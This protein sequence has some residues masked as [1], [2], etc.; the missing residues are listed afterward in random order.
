MITHKEIEGSWIEIPDHVLVYYENNPI[1]AMFQAVYHDF[2]NYFYDPHYIKNRAVV[3]PY[4]ETA[5]DFNEYTLGLLPGPIR[6][7]LSSEKIADSPMTP[8]SLKESYPTEFLNKLTFSGL[9]NRRLNLKIGC[10]IMLLRNISQFTRLCNG[11]RLLVCQMAPNVIEA[12]IISG[13]HIG[14]RVFIPRII[15]IA[16]NKKLP[17]I[18][19]RK[20]FS[21]RVCYAMTINKSQGQSLDHVG[22]FLP[23]PVFS[24]G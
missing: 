7:Y 16:Q 23:K 10:V 14:D 18:L 6:T 5:N 4:Y 2:L 9:P 17:F 12:V 8:E 19:S 13:D 3:T 11:T 24:H 21:V 15:L 20:Q 22:I 1:E